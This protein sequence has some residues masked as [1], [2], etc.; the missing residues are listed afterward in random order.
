VV[1]LN[2]EEVMRNSVRM[3]VVPALVLAAACGRDEKPIDQA[4]QNDLSL[5]S[6]MAG[7][8]PQQ[9]VSPMEMGYGGYGQQPYAQPQPNGYYYPQ[10]PQPVAQRIYRAPAPRA[11]S[12]TY[13]TGTTA[14]TGTRVV[15]NT[16]RDA[17][18]GGVAGAAIGAVTS[19][20]KLK[21]AVIGGVAG[22][23][24][25]AVIGNNVDVKKIPF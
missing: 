12:G 24:L 17:I 10:A 1:R 14:R 15:K 11:S 5:A 16:K 8:Q 9:F 6:S 2:E 20:D 13:S 21:G 3:L 25:G 22:S 23:V 4:L 19:R 18:I 7:Y